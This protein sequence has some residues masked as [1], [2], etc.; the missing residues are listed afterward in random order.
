MLGPEQTDERRARIVEAPKDGRFVAHT[1]PAT[2]HTE[3]LDG[4]PE[5]G[6]VVAMK[7]YAPLTLVLK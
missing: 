7:P 3:S 6:L 4:A 5:N 1:L 2:L